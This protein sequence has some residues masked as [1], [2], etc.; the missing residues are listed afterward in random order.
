MLKLHEF[1]PLTDRCRHC[2]LD[3]GDWYEA[4]LAMAVLFLVCLLAGG[5][6]VHWMGHP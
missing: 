4:I 6:L 2:G 3:R 5:L 1:D